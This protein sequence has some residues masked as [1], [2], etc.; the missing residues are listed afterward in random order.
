MPTTFTQQPHDPERPNPPRARLSISAIAWLPLSILF[1]FGLVHAA[2]FGH[3]RAIAELDV[4]AHPGA[5][6]ETRSAAFL[7]DPGDE[8][9]LLALEPQSLRDHLAAPPGAEGSATIIASEP[10]RLRIVERDLE[11]VRVMVVDGPRQGGR[12][13]TKAERLLVSKRD[14]EATAGDE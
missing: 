4:Q 10:V 9:I 11:L 12:Y 13:W 5:G 7:F 6:N 3:R 8:P 1:G 2:K 14:S